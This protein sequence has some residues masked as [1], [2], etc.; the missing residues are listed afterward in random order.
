MSTIGELIGPKKMTKPTKNFIHENVRKLREVQIMNKQISTGSGPNL[1][2]S[3]QAVSKFKMAQPMLISRKVGS[4]NFLTNSVKM[5]MKATS[6]VETVKS[7]ENTRTNKKKDK[8]LCR[9]QGRENTDPDCEKLSRL[10]IRQAGTTPCMSLISSHRTPK[11][12]RNQETQTVEPKDFDTLY[13]DGVIRYPSSCLRQESGDSSLQG[14]IVREMGLQ[15]ELPVNEG[16]D[17]LLSE[18]EDEYNYIDSKGTIDYVKLNAMVVPKTKVSQPAKHDPS[19]APP[20]YQRGILPKYLRELKKEQ[21]KEKEEKV[22]EAEKHDPDC[23]PGHMPLPDEVRLEHLKI[24][25]HNYADL[26]SQLNKLPVR[27][28][29]LRT[30]VRKREMETE[31]DKIE[32]AMAIFSREKVYIKPNAAQA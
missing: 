28:D 12:F 18:D 22:R 25:K 17:I 20:S 19:R 21:T 1:R 5:P 13:D 26:V 3:V 8:M 32:A 30:R 27:S 10:V 31:L 15:T 11:A 29:T 2:Q 6:Q 9:K 24:L 7:S 23:P 4:T 16:G 14:K